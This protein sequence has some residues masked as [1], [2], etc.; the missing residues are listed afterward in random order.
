MNDTVCLVIRKP[1][2][3]STDSL[4]ALR[5]SLGIFSADVEPTIVLMEDGVF[6]A[7]RGL[8][9]SRAD[10]PATKPF[11]EEVVDCDIP[12]HVVEEDARERGLGPADFDEFVQFVSRRQLG[13][14]IGPHRTVFAF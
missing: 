1:P 2:V 7:V 10:R 11:V 8:D 4:E 6:N 14:L 13:A 12:V 3:G 9:E 5:L